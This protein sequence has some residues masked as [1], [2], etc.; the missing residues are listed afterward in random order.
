MCE[1][2]CCCDRCPDEKQLRGGHFGSQFTGIRSIPAGEAQCRA[3]VLLS[4]QAVGQ[5]PVH[6]LTYQEQSETR[7]RR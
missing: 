4:Q 1:F 6:T 3:A 2:L 7:R 5:L